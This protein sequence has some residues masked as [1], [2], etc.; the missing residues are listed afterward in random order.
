[1]AAEECAW[2][3][4]TVSGSTPRRPGLSR[5]CRDRR[6]LHQVAGIQQDAIVAVGALPPDHGC[7]VG[8]SPVV[9]VERRQARVQIVGMENGKRLG[10]R[11][12][13]RAE[14]QRQRQQAPGLVGH[15]RVL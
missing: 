5:R 9:I 6:A 3:R 8:E 13:Q 7:E 15:Q 4:A 2:F 12:Q 11:R 1:M 10:F 14:Q